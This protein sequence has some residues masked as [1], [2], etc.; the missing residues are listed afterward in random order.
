MSGSAPLD[1]QFTDTSTGTITNRFWDFGDGENSTTQ[2]PSHTYNKDGTYAVTLIVAGPGG[3]SNPKTDIITV[4]A[5]T[6]LTPKTSNT[7]KNDNR[8]IDDIIFR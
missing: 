4:T 2:N 3:A 8:S 7:F 6:Q 5:S 1:T